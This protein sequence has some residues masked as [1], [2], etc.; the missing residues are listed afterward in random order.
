MHGGYPWE[1]EA[2]AIMQQYPQVYMDISPIW[3][4]FGNEEFK[5][6]MELEF[7]RLYAMGLG[8]R[9]MFGTDQMAWP[10]SIGMAIEMIEGSE[11]LTETQKRDILYNNAARFL[12]LSDA[13]VAA[14]HRLPVRRQSS[15]GD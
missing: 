10:E 3:L 7:R 12:G 1:R 9:I 13:E 6:Q 14:H 5:L 4:N 15:N 8:D 11:F 2:Q